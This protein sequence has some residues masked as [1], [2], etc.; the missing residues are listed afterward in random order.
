NTRPSITELNSGEI[1]VS[2]TGDSSDGS[3][4]GIV[5]QIV[6]TGLQISESTVA[7]RIVG[8]VTSVTD[9]DVGD[10]FIYSL[11]DDADGAFTID[12]AT[13]TVTVADPS[14]ID[15]EI[16]ESLTI[17][18]RVTDST[19]LTYDE[20]VTI[21]VIDGVDP[22][23]NPTT[24]ADILSAT[25]GDDVINA[26]AGDD[27]IYA[28]R[29]NDEVLGSE[30][31]DTIFAGSGDD[32]IDGGNPNLVQPDYQ[33]SS[34][35]PSSTFTKSSGET[36]T[37]S[38]VDNGGGNGISGSSFQLKPDVQGYYLGNSSGSWTDSHTHVLSEQVHGVRVRVAF[39]AYQ[40]QIWF[41]LDGVEIDLAQ[42]IADGI[43]VYTNVSGDNDDFINAS[44]H[45]Q[46][47]QVDNTDYITLD[48]N[49]PF[50]TI[51]VLSSG[52][53]GGFSYELYLNVDPIELADGADTIY[54]EA[55]NDTIDGG[56]EDDY[57]DGGA[58]DDTLL[59]GSGNDIL[60]GGSGNDILTGG[61]G[62][63]IFMFD[64]Q[65]NDG[66]VDTITDFALD[67]DK[68]D[69][70]DLLQDDTNPLTVDDFLAGLTVVENNG[71]M[72][73]TIG[74]T[75]QEQ[76]IVIKNLTQADLGLSGGDSADIIT[77]LFNRNVFTID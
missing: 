76:T 4:S 33:K 65:F 26:L 63:D 17:T 24:N 41:A 45:L 20:D 14:K 68:I 50:T 25:S 56:T 16:A 1:L 46:S 44:G 64:T 32:I 60:I 77:E 36:V 9:E 55:G 15:F 39:M 70:T 43:I 66:D 11:V 18:I 58:D 53:A 5:Q 13:G 67:E 57:L 47:S 71:D 31:N 10:V 7:G 3:G 23:I 72:E 19:G 54:G 22:A 27:L 51:D 61:E 28:G 35:G 74:E 2:W 38:S 75:G 69:L 59:G 40:E 6:G 12:A 42:A 49:I 37:M 8:G 29:G 62:D 21:N 48:I 73:I 34:L 52:N 30:G